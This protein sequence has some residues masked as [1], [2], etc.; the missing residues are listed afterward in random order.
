M[1]TRHGANADAHGHGVPK[2][3]VRVPVFTAAMRV[4]V[5]VLV[6]VPVVQLQFKF[7]AIASAACMQIHCQVQSRIKFNGNLRALTP[8]PPAYVAV[9]VPEYVR[10]P[11]ALRSSASQH[12]ASSAA[13]T[14]HAQLPMPRQLELTKQLT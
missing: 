13:V 8:G 14:A 5:A 10:Q 3:P 7:M 9:L 4:A 12:H 11:A 1:R 2:E 6:P